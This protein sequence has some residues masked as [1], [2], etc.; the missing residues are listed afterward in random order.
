[1]KYQYKIDRLIKVWQREY[2]IIEA[3]DQ[4]YADGQAKLLGVVIAAKEDPEVEPIYIETL[5]ETTESVS[6][7]DNKGQA[8]I[9]IMRDDMTIWDNGVKR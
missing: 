9:E 8:T 6:I 2:Y 5:A 1:M 7:Q 4:E 3:E